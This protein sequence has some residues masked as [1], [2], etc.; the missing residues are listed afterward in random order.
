MKIKYSHMLVTLYGSVIRF[1]KHLQ[2]VVTASNYTALTNSGTPLPTTTH[3]DSL[4][5]IAFT[6]RCSVAVLKN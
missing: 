6:S 1:I 5:V 4:S 3:A 2:V